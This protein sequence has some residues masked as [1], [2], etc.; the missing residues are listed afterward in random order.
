MFGELVS[1]F[2]RML[3][4]ALYAAILARVIVSWVAS[5]SSDNPIVAVIYQVTEPILAPLRRVLPTFGTIDF[6]PM[7]AILI[8][9]LVQRVLG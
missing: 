9:A 8:I 7:V 2:I 6:S 1:T 4:W 5:P 3:A